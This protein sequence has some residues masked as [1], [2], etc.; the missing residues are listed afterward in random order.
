MAAYGPKIREIIGA[1]WEPFQNCCIFWAGG[2]NIQPNSAKDVP[3]TTFKFQFTSKTLIFF[4]TLARR[5]KKRL[6]G[7]GA[8]VRLKTYLTREV[9]GSSFL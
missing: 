9:E 3:I 6:K 7:S 1:W 4:V 5:R 2:P 8:L